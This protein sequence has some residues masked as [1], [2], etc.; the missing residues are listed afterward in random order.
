MA[1]M[2][3]G[4]AGGAAAA[5]RPGPTPYVLCCTGGGYTGCTSI[6]AQHSFSW[7]LIASV[8]HVLIVNYCKQG[9]IITSLSIAAHYCDVGGFVSCTPTLA[10]RT[11]GGVGSTSASFQAHAV[12]TVTPLNIYNN[13]D[14]LTLTV[15][16]G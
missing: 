9:G 10:W 12:W 6:S 5:D 8:K 1:V 15:P 14:V 13:T 3:L 16:A 2:A 4:A 7:P 11:G